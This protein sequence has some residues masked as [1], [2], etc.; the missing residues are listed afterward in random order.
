ME[1]VVKV[2]RLRRVLPIWH[3]VKL[4]I[5]QNI[6]IKIQFNR[7]DRF[8]NFGAQLKEYQNGSESH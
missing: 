6:L 8:Q 3:G 1:R 2:H 5:I 4:S 7:K